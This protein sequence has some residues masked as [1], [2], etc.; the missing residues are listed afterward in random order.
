MSENTTKRPPSGAKH[1]PMGRGVP[2]TGAKA[3]DF[4]G[5]MSRLLRYIG[6]YKIAVVVVFIFAIASA[7]F[8]IIGPKLMGNATTVLFEGVMGQISGSGDGIDFVRISQIL[9]MLVI[10]YG[11]SALFGYIQGYIMTGVSN[12]VTYRLRKDISEKVNTLPLSYFDRNSHGDVLSRVTNDVDTISQTLNQS[13]SQIIT[14]ITMVVGVVVMM[15]TINW[16]MTLVVLCIVPIALVLIFQVVKRSQKFFK[17][18]Q[19]YLGSVNGHVEEMFGGHNVIS[20]Y[21]GEEESIE[22]FQGENKKLYDAAWKANFMSGLMQP[23]MAFIGNLGY[24]AVC[25]LGGWFAAQGTITVGNIQ[26]FVQYVRSFT[27][28]LSQLANISNI[29]QQ[30]AAASERVFEFLNEPEES[31][32]TSNPVEL[33]HV[34]GNVEFKDVH[35]GYSPDK[36]IIED[37]SAKVKPGQKIAIVG[38]TGAGKTTMIKLL[39][40]FYDLNSGEI[41]IDGHKST[42]FTRADLRR[43]FGMVLQDTWLYNDTIMENIRYGRMD[44]TDEEVI[45]AAKAAHAHHFIKALPHGYEMVLNEDASNISQGQKQLLTIARAILADPDMLILDEATSSVDTRTEALIQKAMDALMEDR[46]SFVIAHRLSTIKDADLILVMK[47]GDIIEQ[48][49]HDALLAKG[50]FYA[51]LYNS[52]F[53]VPVVEAS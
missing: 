7:V 25:V 22:V 10:L 23:I 19:D 11:I 47:D 39:M 46:T 16:I 33:A 44:A 12:K 4:K 29:L 50:G 32:D 52:Q 20:A 37:F 3:K 34:D 41:L 30:T 40:R 35:F 42:D 51:D 45:A 31:P 14:S 17:Q 43:H 38:P 6:K 36:I 15:F 8:S 21:N 9:I 5:S 1:G 48:G 53:A 27:Q 28:P 24:V 26:S 13:L 49:T 2:M 18:Q